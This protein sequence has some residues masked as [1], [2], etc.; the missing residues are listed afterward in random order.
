MARAEAVRPPAWWAR[1]AQ[2]HARQFFQSLGLLTSRPLGTLM[3][4]LVIGVTLALPASLHLMLEN[5][6]HLSYGWQRA[7]QASLFLRDS[8]DE[9]RG[10]ALAQ[11]LDAR[12]DVDAVSYISREQSLADFRARSGFGAALDELDHNPLPAVIVV[13]PTPGLSGQAVEA[14]HR[15]LAQLPEVEIAQMDQQWLERVHAMLDL[16]RRGVWL[17]AVL[18]GFA[19]VVVVGNTIR[20]DIEARRDEIVVL[21]LIGAPDAF[22]RRPFLYTGFWYGLFGSFVALLMLYVAL[23]SL[24]GPARTLAGAY[25]SDIQLLGPSAAAV[26]LL[27]AAGIGLG[28]I[29][30][31]WTVTRHLRAIEPV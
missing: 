31:G 9:P 3:T 2:D 19:V 8:V 13:T 24:S 4:A 20:L 27:L 29:A 6:D 11:Q 5:V 12:P 15:A 26:L 22:I 25:G 18:L 28:W 17:F 16:A 1:A 21:K 14:L 23:L 30:A 10:R 7:V